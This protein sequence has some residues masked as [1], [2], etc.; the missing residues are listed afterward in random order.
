MS[1]GSL[2]GK[3]WLQSLSKEEQGA[4]QPLAPLT[5]AEALL[6]LRRVAKD[7]RPEAKQAFLRAVATPEELVQAS[8]GASVHLVNV[9]KRHDA[10]LELIA[11]LSMKVAEAVLMKL[12]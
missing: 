5:R 7:K 8:L 3:T 10:A 6:V 9:K 4:L 2:D 11:N 12:L 1:A